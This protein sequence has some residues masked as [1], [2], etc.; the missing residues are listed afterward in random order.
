VFTA[1]YALRPYIKQ[2]RFVFK[3]LI[4]TDMCLN[5]FFEKATST[6]THLAAQLWVTCFLVQQIRA[7]YVYTSAFQRY[8]QRLFSVAYRVCPRRFTPVKESW[9]PL[10]RRLCGSRSGLDRCRKPRPQSGFD[11]WMIQSVASC[12]RYLSVTN[13]GHTLRSSKSNFIS[14]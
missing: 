4:Y 10:Y 13:G 5:K 8:K 1:R 9:N 3:G 2:I 7:Q 12:V 14:I 6:A 11:P